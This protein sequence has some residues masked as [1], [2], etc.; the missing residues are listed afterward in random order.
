MKALFALLIA[1][2]LAAGELTD[3]ILAPG[4]LAGMSAPLHYD[5]QL[6]LDGEVVNERL[7]L[8]PG[9]RLALAQDER[10]LGDFAPESAHPV[11]MYFLESIV[12]HMAEATGGSPHYIR[13]RI[14]EALAAAPLGVA[15][16]PFAEDPNRARMG[17]FAALTLRFGL[18]E[19]GVLSLSADGGGGPD[20]YHET[21][22]LAED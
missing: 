11:V 12:R 19:R 16:Q 10:P 13:N 5:H 9:P 6:H 1:S 2:P 15:V 21:L 7:T 4:A 22:T 17:E 14:R 20:G 18:G 8:S 3:A